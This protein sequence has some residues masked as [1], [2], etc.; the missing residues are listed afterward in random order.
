MSEL[1]IPTEIRSEQLLSIQS[2]LLAEEA[3]HPGRIRTLHLDPLGH[4]PRD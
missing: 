1:P 3:R 4:F 2:Y